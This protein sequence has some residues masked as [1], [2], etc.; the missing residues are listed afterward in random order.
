M[1]VSSS[2]VVLVKEYGPQVKEPIL[3]V[4]FG[5]SGTTNQRSDINSIVKEMGLLFGVSWTD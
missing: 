3:W 4:S 5:N 1:E 2:I